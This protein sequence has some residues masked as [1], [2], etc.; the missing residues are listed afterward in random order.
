MFARALWDNFLG[1]ASWKYKVF[2]VAV[3]VFNPIVVVAGGNVIGA[4]FILVSFLLTLV[5]SLEAYPL[6]AGGLLV[7]EA[8]LLGVT[9]PQTLLH[10]VQCG[11]MHICMQNV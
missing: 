9:T 1:H 5:F 6:Q 8:N 11:H 4:W 3:L 2:V 10:E 7:I